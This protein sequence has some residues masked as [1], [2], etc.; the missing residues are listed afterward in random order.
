MGKLR[1]ALKGKKTYIIATLLAI[2]AFV[3]FVDKGCFSLDCWILFFKTEAIAGLVAT[4]R[5][6]ITKTKS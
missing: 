6:A 3:E 4:I 5:A 1:E 2:V